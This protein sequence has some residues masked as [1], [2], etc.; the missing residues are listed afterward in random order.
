[1]MFHKMIKQNIVLTLFHWPFLKLK[2]EIINQKHK[3]MPF[4]ILSSCFILV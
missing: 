2:G 4:P 3:Y 1:M